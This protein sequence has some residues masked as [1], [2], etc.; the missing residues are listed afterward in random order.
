MRKAMLALTLACVLVPPAG[1]QEAHSLR[2]AGNLLTRYLDR[3]DIHPPV[4]AGRLTIF[5]IS[6]S[7]A[8]RLDGVLTMDQALK[9]GVLAIRELDPPQVS[10]ARFVNTSGREMIFLMAGEVLTGGK[11][12]R[13][14]VSDALL[15]PKSSTELELYCVQKG[16]WQGG[17]AF[18]EKT[19]VAPLSVRAKAARRAGQKEIW[20]EVARANRALG[21]STASDDLAEAMARPENVRRFAELRER[22]TPRLPE[23][24]VGVVVAWGDKI[25]GAD[26][27]NSAGLFAAM[28]EK[29]LN[30][31]LSQYRPEHLRNAPPGG[32]FARPSQA[33]VRQYLQGCY[34]C[35]L[36]AGQLRGVGRIY[37]LRGDRSGQ[38]LGYGG[39]IIPVRP[40]RPEEPTRA[41]QYMVHT[42]LLAEVLPVRPTPRPV[43]RPIPMPR[44]PRPMPQR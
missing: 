34:R 10:Q 18:A 5:P 21:S 14:L 12:S 15:G 32:Q 31:Y 27:F 35:R 20:D 13:T 44:P 9:K 19:T 16:R 39:Q 3:A 2:P 17:A 1:G 29:V 30:S 36:A 41:G 4:E 28:R 26:L 25:L 40:P 23:G 22:I 38:T 37:Q 33:Q 7:R 43:P 6:L 8:R 24:C 42:A 11:Q